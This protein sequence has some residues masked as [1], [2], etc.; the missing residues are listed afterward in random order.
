MIYLLSLLP[1]LVFVA[2]LLWLDSFS[3]VRLHILLL[4]FAGGILSA[5]ASWGC[6]VGVPWLS[7]SVLAVPA[8]EEW[9]KGLGVLFL[10]GRRKSAFF[11][12]AAIYGAVVGAGFAL[13]E[14]L[15]YAWFTPDMQI[16][17]ALVRGFGTAI[18]HCGTVAATAV[19]LSW[20]SHRYPHLLGALYPLALLP[21]IGIHLLYNLLLLPPE[22]M[23]AIIL[24]GVIGLLIALFIWNERS[25]VQWMD[26]EMDTEVKLLS[27]MRKGSFSES[28]AGQY[29][30]SLKEQ[31][32]PECFLDMYCY[33][34]IYLELSIQAKG[35]MLLREAGL[36]VTTTP[37]TAA[38]IKEFYWLRRNIGKT[39]QMALA[40]IV[41]RSAVNEWKIKINN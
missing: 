24:L 6:M 37:D 27:A 19:I 21:A 12:D 9:L 31:F 17:T 26:I 16:G 33:V 4:A 13:F 40:P 25:I 36:P 1:V 3:V 5:L 41:N 15:L 22:I 29:M 2:L 23:L 35:N 18:M 14:N 10:I 11:I 8:L 34:Q 20:I 38:K 32:K 7:T 30:L 39:A 28:K